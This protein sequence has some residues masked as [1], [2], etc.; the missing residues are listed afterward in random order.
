MTTYYRIET[1]LYDLCIREVELFTDYDQAIAR[2]NELLNAI[3][4]D[5]IAHLVE[6]TLSTIER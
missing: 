2:Y 6:V 1:E 4:K 5:N 3:E